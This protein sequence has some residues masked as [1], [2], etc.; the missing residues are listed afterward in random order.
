M[1]HGMDV[2]L[3][4]GHIVVDGDPA[5]PPKGHHPQF[6]A[7]VCCGQT[8]RWIKMP[9][10]TEVGL[11]QGHIA[12]QLPPPKGPQQPPFWPMSIV[13][14]RSPISATAEQLLHSCISIIYSLLILVLIYSQDNHFAVPAV[15]GII[16]SRSLSYV[17]PL[18]WNEIPFEYCNI[19]S[20]TSFKKH[21]KSYVSYPFS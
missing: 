1:K 7:H 3:H 4:P 19:P 8:V 21:L 17:A 14:K 10:G 13:A 11:C 5:L 16:G 6:S 20:L 2:D 9:L 12:L 18:I 15:S